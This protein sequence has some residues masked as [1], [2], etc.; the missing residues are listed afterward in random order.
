MGLSARSAYPHR[1]AGLIQPSPFAC[2][3]AFSVGIINTTSLRQFERPPQPT[4]PLLREGY[5]VPLILAY[6][7]RSASLDNSCRLPSVAG[8]TAGLCPTIWSGLSPRPSPLWVNAPSLRAIIP[9][10]GGEVAIPQLVATSRAFRNRVLRQLLHDPDTCFCRVNLTTLQCSL[11]ATA[12]RLASPPV[13]VRPGV[14][15]PTRTFTPELSRGWSPKPRVG[16]DYT[17]PLG[18]DCDRTFT[19]WSAAVMGCALCWLIQKRSEKQA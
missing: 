16:Y 8:Y 19:G 11:D 12:R 6:T 14:S 2:H 3:P 13:Q 7:T 4:G 5:V 9:T 18:R 15:Q 10:P 1:I 17:A